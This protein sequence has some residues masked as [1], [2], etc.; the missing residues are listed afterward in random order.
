MAGRV[1]FHASGHA[2]NHIRPYRATHTYVKAHAYVRVEMC[3]FL[4]TW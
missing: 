4:L 1:G 3:V 2:G